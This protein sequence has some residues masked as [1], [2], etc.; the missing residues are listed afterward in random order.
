MAIFQRVNRSDPERVFVVFLNNNG[1]STAAGDTAQLELNSASIDGVKAR[2]V[3]TGNEFAFLGCWDGVTTAG[4]YGLVQTYGYRSS[5]KVFQTN[6]SI[7]TGAV[8]VP[9]AGQLYM[10]SILTTLASNT[11]IT[12]QPVMAVLGQSIASS[13]ASAALG[14]KVFLRA[15]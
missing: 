6:T 5:A 13:A 1:G 14:V 9:V 7:D 4:T 11:S 12:I 10:S 8:L 2:S 3:A 15:M